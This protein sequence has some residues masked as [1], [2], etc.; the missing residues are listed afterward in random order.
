MTLGDVAQQ[1]FLVIVRGERVGTQRVET[2]HA[3]HHACEVVVLGVLLAVHHLDAVA[4]DRKPVLGIDRKSGLAGLAAAGGDHHH[5]VGAA[6]TVDGRC[7]G[8]FQ[9]LDA[10]HVGQGGDRAV[11]SEGMLSITTTGW[12]R[13]RWTCRRGCAWPLR[14]PARPTR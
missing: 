2:A 9:N 1:A 10:G 13:P 3:P 12:C 4:R 14:C 6:R 11:W 8:V 7:G 5:A